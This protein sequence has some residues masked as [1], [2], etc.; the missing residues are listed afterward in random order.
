MV[1]EIK[2]VHL[3]LA[4]DQ[5]DYVDELAQRYGVT[6]TQ[7]IRVMVDCMKQPELGSVEEQLQILQQS[8]LAPQSGSENPPTVFLEQLRQ[9][10]G[11]V[12][13]IA[14]QIADLQRGPALAGAL[15]AAGPAGPEDGG[16]PP[17]GPVPGAGLPPAGPADGDDSAFAGGSQPPS[18]DDVD[19]FDGQESGSGNGSG[20]DVRPEAVADILR[21]VADLRED[22]Q[23]QI[24]G[25]RATL[26]A[27]GERVDPDVSVLLNAIR[28]H[29]QESFNGLVDAMSSSVPKAIAESVSL[30]MQPGSGDLET[31]D[32]LAGLHRRMD[33]LTEYVDGV[34]ES[35]L[36]MEEALGQLGRAEVSAA[37]EERLTRLGTAFNGLA[38]D[39]RPLLD[40]GDAESRMQAIEEK[41]GRMTDLLESLLAES[42]R[43]FVLLPSKGL[44]KALVG[45]IR[46]VKED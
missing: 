9:L 2:R 21:A 41:V 28:D 26:A 17:A 4:G 34:R 11:R 24:E 32:L 19:F 29:L 33:A 40:R 35:L 36:R 18:F 13:F 16:M 44:G 31:K 3:T 39:L 14:R 42:S 10:S 7:V 27:L 23:E 37:V 46:L 38:A 20:M 6:R 45:Q 15:Q 22:V 8:E 1:D 43:S 25:M 12:E 5:A 30:E